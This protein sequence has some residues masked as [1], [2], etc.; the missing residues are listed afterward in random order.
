[1]KNYR[2]ELKIFK[3]LAKNTSDWYNQL[4]KSEADESEYSMENWAKHFGISDKNTMYMYRHVRWEMIR[5]LEKEPRGKIMT[6]ELEERIK[7]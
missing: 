7:S 1:M 6:K 2:E 3:K 5:L 4:I